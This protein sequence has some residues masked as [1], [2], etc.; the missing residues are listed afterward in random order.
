M[1]FN[2]QVAMIRRHGGHG[3]P[4]RE[5]HDVIDRSRIWGIHWLEMVGV[6]V[7]L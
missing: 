5:A 7:G 3:G 6:S 2:S 1:V 4:G